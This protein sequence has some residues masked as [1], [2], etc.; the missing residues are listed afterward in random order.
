MNSIIAFGSLPITE[1]IYAYIPVSLQVPI[2][3]NTHFAITF[4][5]FNSV[6][7][8]LQIWRYYVPK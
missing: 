6:N 3:T 1:L 2:D 4:C 5:L 7:E 8:V